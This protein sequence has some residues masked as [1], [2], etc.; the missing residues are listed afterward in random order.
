[1]IAV[2][3]NYDSFTFNLVQQIGSLTD[4]TIE[5]VRSD[6]FEVDALVGSGPRAIVISPGP[7]TPERAGN[8]IDLVRHADRIPI[9]GVCLGHQA[10]AAAFGAAIVRATV[11][12]H[13]KAH[14]I[15]HKGCGLFVGVEGPLVG[16][17]YHSLVID[18]STL[19]EVIRVDATSSDGVIMAIAHKERPVFGLQF[20][21]ESF[22]TIG[23]DGLITRFLELGG[24][25]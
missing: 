11:P 23:G 18:P 21:P 8:C 15:L 14:D 7:G 2:I 4:E 12:V 10:I 19:P 22:G 13:G 3:D 9:L 6:E 1:M 17:R 16:A 20:H 5:V 25:S 24:I